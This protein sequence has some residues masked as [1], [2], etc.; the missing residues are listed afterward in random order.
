MSSS[1]IQKI[2]LGVLLVLFSFVLGSEVSEGAKRPVL[3]LAGLGA[4][5]AIN[6]L[7]K[8]AWVL[9]FIA[10]V[11]MRYLP[12]GALKK[13]SPGYLVAT[14]VLAYY[15]A[16]SF[17]GYVRLKWRSVFFCDFL[18]FIVFGAFLAQFIRYPVGVGGLG[19]INGQ[20]GGND[21]IACLFA[22]LFYVAISCMPI[23]FENIAKV[24]KWT[25]YITVVA[26]FFGAIFRGI[27]MGGEAMEAAKSSRF[28]M[29][30]H[31]GQNLF[32]MLICCN[33][34]WQ[35]VTSFWKSFLIAVSLI[36]IILSGFRNLLAAA[37]AHWITLSC[38]RRQVMLVFA[39]LSVL[40]GAVFALSY[41]RV[42]LDLPL[43]MQRACSFLPGV[44]VDS[45]IA[46]DAKFSL[47]WRYAMWDKAMDPREGYI[48]D[49]TWGDGF[50][51]KLDLLQR[52]KT[53]ISRG[54]IK[55]GD[56]KTFMDYGVWHSGYIHLIHRMGYVG[57]VLI[58]F[59]M[60]VFVILAL[61]VA[62]LYRRHP[63]A[64]GIWFAI[65]AL[66][67][68]FLLFFGST[69]EAS[70]FF[71]MYYAFGI[72]KIL[73]VCYQEGLSAGSTPELNERGQYIPL[74]M[75][76]VDTSSNRV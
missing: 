54:V 21:Y 63:A 69:G 28:T 38:V 55:A 36:C 56:N 52:N 1:I 76:E 61:K 24:L 44:K 16:L 58:G 51:L 11:V 5:F 75:R 53:L 14:I 60:F 7:G 12:L 17:M 62:Y 66:P 33:T 68:S 43:G 45:A 72:S 65:I 2:I 25:M 32:L 48:K 29:F 46:R 49:Y 74:M 18:V 30:D 59:T 34:P 6:A 27:G 57:L 64:S 10:P 47:E 19:V 15:I 4:L 37:A 50:G 71:G 70:T 22:T 23:T 73:Y 9:V 20:V 13:I 39:L 31:F 41:S 40:Y 26:A 67:T 42:M 3:I 35:I 8:R